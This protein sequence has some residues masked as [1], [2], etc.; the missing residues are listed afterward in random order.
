LGLRV[1]ADVVAQDDRFGNF[2]HGA[3]LLAALALDG[4]VGLLFVQ[5]KISLQDAFRA[6][7]YFARLQLLR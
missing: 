3:A 1:A 7:D 6:L 2:F 5:S 4:Q